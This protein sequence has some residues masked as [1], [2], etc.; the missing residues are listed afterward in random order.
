LLIN[1]QL[2]SR[3]LILPVVLLARWDQHPLVFRMSVAQHNSFMFTVPV[4]DD[5]L[6]NTIQYN[7]SAVTTETTTWSTLIILVR[8][9][10]YNTIHC[11]QNKL[12]SINS[13]YSH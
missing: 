3:H 12:W 8:T 4:Q 2:K 11:L 6:S 10:T 9:H 7:R 5:L 13:I 1:G